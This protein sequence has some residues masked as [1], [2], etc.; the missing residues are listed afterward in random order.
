MRVT[1]DTLNEIRDRVLGDALRSVSRSHKK[2]VRSNLKITEMTNVI[3]Q[4]T[5]RTKKVSFVLGEVGQGTDR[6]VTL[7]RLLQ[8][9]RLS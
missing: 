6:K 5:D 3:L 7:D 9:L 4:G 2:S 1:D 8:G